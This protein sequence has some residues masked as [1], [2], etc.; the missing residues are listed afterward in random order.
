[1]DVLCPQTKQVN[2]SYNNLINYNVIED[3]MLKKEI[4]D[5]RDEIIKTHLEGRHSFGPIGE[6]KIKINDIELSGK[7]AF[8]IFSS[9]LNKKEEYELRIIDNT[10]DDYSYLLS[11]QILLG[12]KE[13]ESVKIIISFLRDNNQSTKNTAIGI[14]RDNS[15]IILKYIDQFIKESQDDKNL[16]TQIMALGAIGHKAENQ[17]HL[18]LD[19]MKSTNSYEVKLVITEV[20]ADIGSQKPIELL[21]ELYELENDI[22]LR[23]EIVETLGRLGPNQIR[24]KI[25][26]ILNNDQDESIRALAAEIT[27][28]IRNGGDLI[29]EELTKA[30]DDNSDTVKESA[31][32]SLGRIYH[33]SKKAIEKLV[34]LSVESNNWKVCN[35]AKNAVL[36]LAESLGY[37]NPND[38]YET[39][40]NKIGEIPIPNIKKSIEGESNLVFVVMAFIEEMEPIFEGINTAAKKFGLEAKR[41]SDVSGDYKITDKIIEMIQTS[42]IIIA[43]LTFERPNVYFELGYARGIGKKVYTIAK[44]GTNIHFDVKDWKCIFYTDS[45][46]IEK[47]LSKLFKLDTRK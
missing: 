13:R 29:I 22:F 43:D 39:I 40:K 28:R 12:D 2:I 5:K 47:E 17:I 26:E 41:V 44:T 32:N 16:I 8:E 9:I 1:M 15:H 35:V 42:K 14:I 38:Y 25:I 6:D 33:E 7:E 11:R 27:V 37:K 20:F 10:L 19:I 21:L 34:K 46:I 24:K 30:L 36:N 23:R 3:V 31:A 45:R 18:L 4:K